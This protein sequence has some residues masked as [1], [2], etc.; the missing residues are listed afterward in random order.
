MDAEA[1]RLLKSIDRN[2]EILISLQQSLIDALADDGTDESTNGGF[3][4]LS[5]TEPK[6]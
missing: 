5:E 3:H 1:I 4:A 6:G 2:L